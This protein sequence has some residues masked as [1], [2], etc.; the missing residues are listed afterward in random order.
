MNINVENVGVVCSSHKSFILFIQEETDF[1]R[2]ELITEN[3][4]G[5]SISYNES[6]IIYRKVINEDH[7]Q[8]VVFNRIEVADIGVSERLLNVAKS[9][10]R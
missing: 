9:R 8:G 2:S 6:K 1:N 3:Y 4:N 5:C 10:I 7:C